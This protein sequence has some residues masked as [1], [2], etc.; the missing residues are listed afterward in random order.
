LSSDEPVTTSVIEELVLLAGLL[1]P[2]VVPRLLD[3]SIGMVLS[4]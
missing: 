3:Q 1:P 4:V 2:F